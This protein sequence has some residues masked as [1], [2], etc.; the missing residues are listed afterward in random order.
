MLPFYLLK[1]DKDYKHPRYIEHS[2]LAQNLCEKTSVRIVITL[3]HDLSKAIKNLLD[4]NNRAR[5]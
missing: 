1:E 5:N 2:N 4:E 3:S